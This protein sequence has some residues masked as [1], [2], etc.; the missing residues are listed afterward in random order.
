MFFPCI[1]LHLLFCPL[2]EPF[3]KKYVG[4]GYLREEQSNRLW[5]FE[6]QKPGN[7]FGNTGD[8]LDQSFLPQRLGS[9]GIEG[10]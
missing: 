4:N 3:T 10:V 8:E 2:F 1:P 7:K 6:S 5:A 9:S